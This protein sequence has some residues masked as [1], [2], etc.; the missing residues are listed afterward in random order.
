[1]SRS[2]HEV[3]IRDILFFSNIDFIYEPWYNLEETQEKAPTVQDKTYE[4]IFESIKGAAKNYN[5]ARDENGKP[6][7]VLDENGEPVVDPET[8]KIIY[9]RKEIDGEEH[10]AYENRKPSPD[11]LINGSLYFEVFGWGGEVYELKK[12]F[13]KDQFSKL[14]E[15]FKYIEKD[16]LD[17]AAPSRSLKAYAEV[18]DTKVCIPCGEKECPCNSDLGLRV[19]IKLIKVAPLFEASGRNISLIDSYID[20]MSQY[21]EYVDDKPQETE[22]LEKDREFFNQNI[23]HYWNWYNKYKQQKYEAWRQNFIDKHGKEPTSDDE[24]REKDSFIPT[25][26]E[27]NQFLN[28]PREAS[29]SNWY[30]ISQTE[31][32]PEPLTIQQIGQQLVSQGYWTANLWSPQDKVAAYFKTPEALTQALRSLGVQVDEEPVQR[33]VP[34]APVSQERAWEP[35]LNFNLSKEKM[36]NWQQEQVAAFAFNLSRVNY[37]RLKS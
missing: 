31:N 30:K 16:A 27:I 17:L 13:K 21:V 34:T 32:F 19:L 28:Q 11:F 2:Y 33:E 14:L 26:Q 8:K 36:T 5:L 4:E 29:S 22:Q 10:T 6:I 24:W 1:M 7:P 23:Q 9:K 37:P 35:V 15:D 18:L 3:V 20:H 12:E 25:Q